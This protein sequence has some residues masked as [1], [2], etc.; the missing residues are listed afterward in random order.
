[1]PKRDPSI[2]EAM[3]AFR[4]NHS[5]VQYMPAK[6]IK[7][8]FKAFL[9][10]EAKSGYALNWQLYAGKTEHRGLGATHQVVMELCQ[11]FEGEGTRIYLDRYYSG[12]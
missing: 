6:P 4:G 2:D 11:G 1:M 12:N 8:G 7:F 10:F 3:I 5:L 9:L